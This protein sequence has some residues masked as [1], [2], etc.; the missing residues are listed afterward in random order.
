MEADRLISSEIENGGIE[1][2]NELILSQN[3]RMHWD[4]Q[5]AHQIKQGTSRGT[6]GIEKD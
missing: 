3:H 4:Y 2:I 6:I 1:E 5:R